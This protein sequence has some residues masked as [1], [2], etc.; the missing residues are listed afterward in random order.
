SA[1]GARFDREVTAL[2]TVATVAN[3][4]FLVVSAQDRV[5]IARNNVASAE[6]ILTVI[7]DRFNAGTAAA[8]DVAQ[9]ETLVASQ[10]A[11]IPPLLIQEQQNKQA[12]ALLVGRP[13]ERLVVRGGTVSRIRIP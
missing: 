11:T 4:Y 8:L 10:R 3:T 2:S 13:P 9:Q 1:I 6:R 12:L 7:R 5:R